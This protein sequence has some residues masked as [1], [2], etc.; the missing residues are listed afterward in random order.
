MA[1][2]CSNSS[3]K[4]Q[5]SN[6]SNNGGSN[7]SSNQNKNKNQKIR[8]DCCESDSPLSLFLCIFMQNRLN[9]AAGKLLR[10]KLLV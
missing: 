5:S 7:K 9:K 6:S 3:N 2:N 10:E 4:N 1:K 8:A